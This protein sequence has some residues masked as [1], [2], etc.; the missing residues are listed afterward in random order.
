MK[1][2]A[3]LLRAGLVALTLLTT[4]R[5]GAR[6][7]RAS[8]I[9]ELL[10]RQDILILDTE[11]TGVGPGAEVGEVVAID[12]TGALRV[13]E[14][15][16]PVGWISIDSWQVHGLTEDALHALGARPWPVV[17]RTVAAALRNSETVLAWNA[18]F[19]A[20]VLAQSAAIHN[21]SLPEVRWADIRP[22]YRET[23]PEG[24]HS[25]ADAMHREK[26]DWTGR[27]HRAE[28]DCRAVLSVMRRIA[29]IIC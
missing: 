3:R 17:H 4:Q 19:D 2:I 7:L 21:L 15:A 25:L 20:R 9:A 13:S 16:L 18:D 29:E 6:R 24:G 5:R 8:D 11:T 22:A 23:R 14:L 10:D 12:T 1:H 27:Q 26:L 28:A